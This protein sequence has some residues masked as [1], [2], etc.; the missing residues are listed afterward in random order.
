[1]LTKRFGLRILSAL[2]ILL[3]IGVWIKL[4]VYKTENIGNRKELIIFCAG[5]LSIPLQEV[6]KE[7]QRWVKGTYGYDVEIKLEASG[8]VMAVRKVV[9]LG[10][11]ADIVAVADYALIPKLM[12]PDYTSFYILFATNELVIAYTQKSKYASIINSSNWYEILAK[13][14]VKF[15]FS[16]PNLDPCGY[17]SV[18]AIKPAD[19]YYGKPIFSELIEKHT[20]IKA[21]NTT[22]FVPKNVI[23]DNKIV[24]R[25][26][27]VDLL[28]LLESNAIDYAFEY[29]SVAI[30]HNLKFV[31]LPDEINLKEFDLKD[32]YRKVKINLESKN[33]T[34]EAK[35][36]IYGVTIPK[37]APHKELAELYL[38][39]LLKQ[40]RDIFE[41]NHQEFLAKP[42]VFG[43][44]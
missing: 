21:R 36:I 44:F 12:Y 39:F 11:K 13:P 34:I 29:K 37:N 7:F 19:L 31:E 43:N 24:I 20:N 42:I 41:R 17:R 14:D 3:L 5:S 23:T 33:K 10:K 28:A 38:Q 22:I 30:Q 6:N 2:T 32:L 9:D 8:S 16:N 15:G 26:K 1:M 4:H 27:S 25:D 18:M 40:G 35:P